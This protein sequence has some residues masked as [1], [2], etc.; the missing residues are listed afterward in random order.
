MGGHQV[1]YGENFKFF[2]IE[3]LSKLYDSKQFEPPFVEIGEIKLN[4]TMP[5]AMTRIL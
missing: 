2:F 5:A 3:D 1:A 4:I